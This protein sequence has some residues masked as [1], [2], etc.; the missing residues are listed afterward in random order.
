M[1]LI[2]VRKCPVCQ[3]EL[4][5]DAGEDN[6]LEVKQ[7]ELEINML[8]VQCK[9]GVK[10]NAHHAVLCPFR[11]LCDSVLTLLLL[12]CVLI[13]VQRV[14]VTQPTTTENETTESE[15]QADAAVK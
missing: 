11:F 9:N 6:F 7:L 8:P 10:C 5:P 12:L 2:L 13:S 14:S 3:D 4:S 15:K 1:R